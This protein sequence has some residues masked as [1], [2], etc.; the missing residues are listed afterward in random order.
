MGGG[1][2]ER[3]TSLRRL[4]NSNAATS[5]VE[6]SHE[7]EP[8]HQQP[9]ESTDGPFNTALKRINRSKSLLSTSIGVTFLPPTLLIDLA[10]KEIKHPNRRLKGDEK[11]AL[12]SIL[13]WTGTGI[14]KDGTH[15][16]VAGKGMSGMV[17]FVRQQEFQVV[18]SRHV[19]SA[20]TQEQTPSLAT[21]PPPP[22]VSTTSTTSTASTMTTSTT[23]TSTSASTATDLTPTPSSL[24][25]F[26]VYPNTCTIC[27]GRPQWLTYRYFSR[28]N[29]EDQCLGEFIHEMLATANLPCSTVGCGFKCGEHEMRIV[30]AGVR[31]NVVMK[32][33]EWVDVKGE[34]KEEEEGKE[35]E[36]TKEEK[37]KDK[38]EMWESCRIC[39]KKS[40]RVG[41]SDGTL[42][43]F[44][45]F[46]LFVF[47]TLL[48]L[49]FIFLC[50]IPR[51]PHLFLIH[52]RPL[53]SI[54]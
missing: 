33:Y 13:G 51:T 12:A 23:A 1:G 22:T 37:E 44:L 32:D 5:V 29:S 54:M 47:L 4:G 34:E 36:K 35:E 25:P 43:V 20:Q 39:E 52:I 16:Y 21:Q 38:I 14:G 19:P 42:Y 31:I 9:Q 48:F 3:R 49:Q 28:S 8:Q 10:A 45:H 7:H 18:V 2:H 50:E 53:T 11:A 30:H 46:G 17:G 24:T 26:K 27:C 6:S 15:G 40:E 41:M